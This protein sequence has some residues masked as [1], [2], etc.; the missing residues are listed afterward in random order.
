MNLLNQH[1]SY[2]LVLI[3]KCKHSVSLYRYNQSTQGHNTCERFNRLNICRL[4]IIV[5][6]FYLVGRRS[7]AIQ[8]NLVTEKEQ[9]NRK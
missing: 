4:R 6:G 1:R 3:V 2:N 8:V 5:E 7:Y 9:F